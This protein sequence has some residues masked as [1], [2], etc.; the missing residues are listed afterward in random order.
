[1]PSYIY[2]YLVD[3]LVSRFYG[4]NYVNFTSI[5]TRNID[6][7]LPLFIMLIITYLW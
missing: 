6:I 3:D 5:P 2:I 7:S 4:L 1:M